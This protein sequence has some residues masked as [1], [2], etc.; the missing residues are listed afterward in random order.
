RLRDSLC[1]RERGGVRGGDAPAQEL[2][3][4]SGEGRVRGK[5]K[6][7]LSYIRSPGAETR[8]ISVPQAPAACLRMLSRLLNWNRK[9]P[10]DHCRT[11]PIRSENTRSSSRSASVGSARSTGDEIRSS[12]E[13]SRS[14]PA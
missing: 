7:L 11:S 12:N 13:R 14:K 9:P 10:G 8:L 2:P 6:P 5:R 4:P 3:L 1:P